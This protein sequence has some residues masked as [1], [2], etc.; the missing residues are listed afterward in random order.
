MTRKTDGEKIDELEKLVAR[1]L[2]QLETVEKT[3]DSLN[4]ARK[5]TV[6]RLNDLQRESEKRI[7]VLQEQTSKLEA[8]QERAGTRAWSVVPNIVGAVVSGILAAIVAYFVARR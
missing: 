7:V 2:K 3:L 1:I 5:E 4:D 6:Q 8:T